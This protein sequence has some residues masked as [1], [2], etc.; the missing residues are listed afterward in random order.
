[1]D[2]DVG[3]IVGWMGLLSILIVL[4]V[5]TEG[6]VMWMGLILG[7]IGVDYILV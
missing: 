6:L 2:T 3:L 4:C 5:Y 7:F 1:M